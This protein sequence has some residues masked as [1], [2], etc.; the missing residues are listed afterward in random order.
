M[1]P[2]MILFITHVYPK[3]LLPVLVFDQIF[4]TNFISKC[5]QVQ[6]NRLNWKMRRP[7]FI[8]RFSDR[9]FF[10]IF[11]SLSLAGSKNRKLNCSGLTGNLCL[12]FKV[13]HEYHIQLS[14]GY[15]TGITVQGLYHRDHC[16]GVIPQGSLSR[17][18]AKGINVQGLYHRDHCPGIMLQ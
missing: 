9:F 6:K 16:P 17:G 8:F 1:L 12:T 2:L 18:Y 3:L 13:C 15:A 10:S 11:E 4:G 5:V 7:F 14:G